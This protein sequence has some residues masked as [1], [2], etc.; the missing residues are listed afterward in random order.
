MED[1]RKYANTHS[2]FINTVYKMR[3]RLVFNEDSKLQPGLFWASWVQLTYA[4]KQNI[5][6]RD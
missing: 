5:A 2:M 6:T 3:N 1:T 4:C